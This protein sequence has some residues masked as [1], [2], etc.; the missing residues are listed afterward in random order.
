MLGGEI[1]TIRVYSISA[2]AH[3]AACGG[4][5]SRSHPLTE[6]L[7]HLSI[8]HRYAPASNMVFHSAAATE[9]ASIS[10]IIYH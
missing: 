6:R 5:D 8:T 9:T 1:K 7:N 4:T 2:Y 3:N 10:N